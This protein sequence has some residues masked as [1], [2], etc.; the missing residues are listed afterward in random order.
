M[1]PEIS[2]GI[3]DFRELREEP[4][5]YPFIDKSLFIR[6]VIS[7]DKAMLFTRPRRFGK[8]LNQSMLYYYFSCNE[9]DT[10]KLFN[11]LKIEKAGE[12]YTAQQGQYPTIAIT[13]KEVEGENFYALLKKFSTRM[14]DSYRKFSYLAA[15]EGLLDEYEQSYFKKILSEQAEK[16]ELEV[17]LLRL[18]GWLC[19]HYKKQVVVL[20]DEYDAPI[21][22]SFFSDDAAYYTSTVSFMRSLLGDA[23]KDNNYLYKGV[24][25]GISDAAKADIFSGA[26]NVETYSLLDKKY[27][28]YFGFTEDEVVA[29]LHQ[30]EVT[31]DLQAVREWYNGYY[32]AGNVLYN[33]KSILSFISRGELG[34]YW[35]DTSRDEQLKRLIVNAGSL[36]NE[37]I[38]A[39]LQ[40]Q[41]VK[42]RLD[43]SLVLEELKTR[44]T[45]AMSL[46]YM[47]GYVNA[48]KIATDIP[49]AI[50]NYQLRIPNKEVHSAFE[51]FMTRWLVGNE[52]VEWLLESLNYL[53]EGDI[54]R[55]SVRLKKIAR[56]VFS[57]YN[58]GANDGEKFY[59]GFLLCLALF[60]GDDYLA[61]S[62][63]EAG[64]GRADIVLL[65][66]DA[67]KG[68]KGI[69]LELKRAQNASK[70]AQ[71][72]EAAYQQI[73]EKKYHQLSQADNA[74]EW[75]KVG[76]AFSGK[77]VS[78]FSQ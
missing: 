35:A 65:P 62:N 54:A 50:P 57:Y 33:P 4:G 12:R 48:I 69:I 49:V 6:D 20:I 74:K 76:V 14:A 61:L 25:T 38:A 27:A 9:Q 8:T 67:K 16:H 32:L 22:S 68:L 44:D 45:A 59:H 31:T 40:G 47:A 42:S 23:L 7:G 15:I 24:L 2:L 28:E 75:L 71:L 1:K 34:A 66:K 72:A 58:T 63:R 5:H 64:D 41:A 18:T 43:K 55:F 36:L 17:S 10:A 78:V 73:E 70:L 56:N 52:Q 37:Q 26:N 11:G 51:R 29:L 60:I 30:F 21:R 13:L 19:H 77:E 46:L 39:L 53:K 3:S